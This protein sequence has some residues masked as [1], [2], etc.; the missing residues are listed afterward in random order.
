MYIFYMKS[1][2]SHSLSFPQPFLSI[3][4]YS[5]ESP[6]LQAKIDESFLLL[7]CPFVI[8]LNQ[9]CEDRAILACQVI[10]SARARALQGT[11]AL[12]TAQPPTPSSAL[13]NS[14]AHTSQAWQPALRC[15]QTLNRPHW[16]RTAAC[17]LQALRATQA[18][19]VLERDGISKL[20]L[21]YIPFSGVERLS[22]PHFNTLRFLLLLVCHSF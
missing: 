16:E 6:K 5:W 4:C 15:H 10:M 9:G 21:L 17:S 3:H 19:K 20:M 8:S 14:L 22:T 13:L 11:S 2:Q 7:R 12:G 1:R 18:H